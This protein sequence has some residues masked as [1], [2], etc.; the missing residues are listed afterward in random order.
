VG[1]VSRRLGFLSGA[2][3]VSTRP[4]AVLTGPRAHVLGVVRAFEESGWQ[5]QRYIVGD[6]VPLAWVAEDSAETALRS[7]LATRGAADLLRCGMGLVNGWRARRALGE[8]DLVYERLGAFQAMGW[9]FQRR[10]VPWLLETNALLFREAVRDRSSVALAGLLEATERWAYQQCDVVVCVS[11]AL[12]DLVIREAGVDPRKV[13]VLPNGVDVSQFDPAAHPAMRV[14]DGPTVGFVGHLQAW[15]RL[16]LLIEA[17]ASL[18]SEGVRVNLVVVGDGPMRGAWESLV[19]TR[20]LDDQVR[21]VG[22]VAWAEVPAYVAGFDIA[23]AGAATL[24]TGTMYLSPLKLYEYASMARPFLASDGADARQLVTD[25]GFLFDPGNGE[26]VLQSLRYALSVRG[27]WPEIGE[28]ARSR[29]LEEHSWKARIR[30]L[31]AE[32]RPI[33][34][35]EYGKVVDPWRRS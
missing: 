4:E 20:S 30:T 11:Q 7:S 29:V 23:Y 14:F 17:L 24:S 28:R 16:D 21:F 15:Q 3:R 2:A 22:R 26:A 6:R 35:E 31:M 34:E 32:V 8:V 27:R 19:R 12:A 9:W 1:K 10:R 5:V 33:L 25:K 18:R 13:V